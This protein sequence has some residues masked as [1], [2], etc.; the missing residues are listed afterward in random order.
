MRDKKIIIIAAIAIIAIIGVIGAYVGFENASTNS[1]TITDMVGRSVNLPSEIN[2]TY[3]TAGQ[4][5]YHY[6]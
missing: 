6:T 2:K 5:P 4:L 1:S 3:S